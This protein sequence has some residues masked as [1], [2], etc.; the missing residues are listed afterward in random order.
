MVWLT[1]WMGAVV[2][3][4]CGAIW[5]GVGSCGR[6]HDLYPTDRPGGTQRRGRD[7]SE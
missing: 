7:A 5:R 1:L 4:V 6:R 2:G 3:F